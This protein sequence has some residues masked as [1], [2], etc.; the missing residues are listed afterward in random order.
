MV[1]C[2][3]AEA[4]QR[5]ETSQECFSVCIVRRDSVR[6]PLELTILAGTSV[7]EDA[8]KERQNADLHQFS[9]VETNDCHR[10][11]FPD[12]LIFLPCP[13]I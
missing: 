12:N 10:A 4:A 8:T 13:R 7:R 3:D 1:L 6:M 11:R 5:L 9:D 2:Q